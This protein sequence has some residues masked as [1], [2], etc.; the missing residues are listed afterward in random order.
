MRKNKRIPKF[1]SED[2]ER[3]FWLKK[4]FADYLDSFKRIKFDFSRLKPS[5][6]SITIRLPEPLLLSIRSLAN[7]K[8]VHYQSLMKMYLAEK[9]REELR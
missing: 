2:K 1:A 9:V 7:K 3:D 4:D 8:D 6:K 5:T